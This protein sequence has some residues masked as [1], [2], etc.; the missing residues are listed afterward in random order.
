MIYTLQLPKPSDN[1]INLV[2]SIALARPV[3][4]RSSNWHSSIQGPNINCAAGDFFSDKRVTLLAVQEFQPL[5][6]HSI[7]AIIGVIHNINPISLASYPPHTD[8]VRTASIN[9]YIELG[10]NNVKTIFY[11]K[12]S[13][14]DI[15]GKNVDVLPYKDVSAQQEYLFDTDTWYLLNSRNFHSVENIK[16]T[17]II[18]GISFMDIG[19]E[20]LVKSLAESIGIEP[21]H[22]Y[23]Q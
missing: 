7:Y 23:S 16:T 13:V 4:I 22:R 2:K 5:F 9:F 8:K 11:D 3:N 6:K 1:L 18:L 17:R 20:E 21:M 12:E 14:T 15:A 10:G 19:I